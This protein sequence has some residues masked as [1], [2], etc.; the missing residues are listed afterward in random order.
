[1]LE[2]LAASKDRDSPRFERAALEKLANDACLP[3]LNER[4]ARLLS[5][6]G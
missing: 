5:Q 3:A 6:I 2:T 1:M 4:A